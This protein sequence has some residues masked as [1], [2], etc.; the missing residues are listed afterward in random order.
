M[1]IQ[2]WHTVV[3]LE[4]QKC[5]FPSA[6]DDRLQRD[7]F[8]IGLNDTSKHFISDLISG[9]NLTTLTFAQVI[10]KALD[11]EA[12]LKTKSAVTRQ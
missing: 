3:R 7:I 11:F 12:I 1:S 9:E 5:N 2:Q 4:Y 6:V 10:S 8:V